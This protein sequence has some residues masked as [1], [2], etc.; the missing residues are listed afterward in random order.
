MKPKRLR[1]RW[2][3]ATHS[4]TSTARNEYGAI[5]LG[6]GRATFTIRTAIGLVSFCPEDSP[7][8]FF[9]ISLQYQLCRIQIAVSGSQYQS[10]RISLG[11]RRSRRGR[12][13]LARDLTGLDRDP[14]TAYREHR[15]NKRRHPRHGHPHPCGPSVVARNISD[16]RTRDSYPAAINQLEERPSAG[17]QC[18]RDVLEQFRILR[19]PRDERESDQS[20]KQEH[21]RAEL[22]R[23]QRIRER[24]N[25]P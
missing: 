24:S 5:R 14:T 6:D 2:A 11:R 12:R 3:M 15:G 19:A 1:S 17:L 13:M 21:H 25:P 22:E 23:R 4:P 9:S 8:P 18:G 20:A 16:Q 10:R 7:Y